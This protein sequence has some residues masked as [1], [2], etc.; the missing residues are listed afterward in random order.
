MLQP[1]SNRP[2][3]WILRHIDTAG[4]RTG[5]GRAGQAHKYSLSFASTPPYRSRRRAAVGLCIMLRCRWAHSLSSVVEVELRVDR[6][7]RER[8]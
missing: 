3:L 2:R 8:V 4:Q 6:T 1:W 7:G 5:Q